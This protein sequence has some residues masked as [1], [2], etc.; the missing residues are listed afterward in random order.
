[1]KICITTPYYRPIKGGISNYV[2]NL[3][4]N[5]SEKNQKTYIIT[6]QGI[7]DT[8]EVYVAD[9]N[10]F[11]FILKA[12]FHIRALKPDVLHSHAHWYLLAPCVIYKIFKPKTCLIHTFHTDPIDKISGFKL[13][14][15][16]RLLSR[17]DTLTFVSKYLHDKIMDNFNINIKT[18]IIYGGVTPINLDEYEI[19]QFKRK[20]NLENHYPVISFVG[21]LSWKMKAEGVKILTEAFKKVLIEFPNSRLLIVGDGVYRKDIESLV[22]K[23]EIESE[24]IF[25]GFVDNA[26][27]PLA[28]SD[29]YAH[30]SLQE[31]FPLAVLEAMSLGKPVIAS[32]T[33]GI[34]EVIIDG[35]NGI[36]VE[37]NSKSIVDAVIMLMSF[38]EQKRILGQNAIKTVEHRFTWPKIVENILN[39]YNID[40]NK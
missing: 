19:N 22:N 33:G 32:N 26:F 17:C 37:T 24:V 16:K 13:V 11:F 1:M 35:E 2:L 39:I 3:S 34:P 10:K 20:F 40:I 6:K 9:V 25:T 23:L 29:I 5:L 28:A 15:M 14:L 38:P 21:A 27:I 4:D 8:E 31:G 7:K 30:I 12:F 36:L 18:K